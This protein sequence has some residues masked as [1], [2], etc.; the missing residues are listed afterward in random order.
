MEYK[1]SD[2]RL[3]I[4]EYV[5]HPRYRELLSLRYCD[6]HTYEEIAELVNYSPQHVKHICKTYKALLMSRV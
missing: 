2:M 4:A 5:H 3:A 6:G 1:N